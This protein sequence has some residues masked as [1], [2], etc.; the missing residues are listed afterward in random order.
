MKPQKIQIKIGMA[1][2]H[3]TVFNNIVTPCRINYAG[4]GTVAEY[5][6]HV[7]LTL[8]EVVEEIVNLGEYK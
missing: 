1:T 4:H 2:M 8:T 6:D 7:R 3:G 5:E